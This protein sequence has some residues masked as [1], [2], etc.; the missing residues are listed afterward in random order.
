MTVKNRRESRGTSGRPQ[1]RGGGGPRRTGACREGSWE[2]WR[3]GAQDEGETYM[4]GFWGRLILFTGEA[5]S[6]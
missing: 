1:S 5:V 2:K 4:P 3:D 6:D